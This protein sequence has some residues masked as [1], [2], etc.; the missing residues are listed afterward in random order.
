MFQPIRR[1]KKCRDFELGIAHARISKVFEL[2]KGRS[3][4]GFKSRV[5]AAFGGLD[6]PERLVIL[7]RWGL[8]G[9]E[10][11]IVVGA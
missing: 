6:R 3:E 5:K 9:V 11:A 7:V 10:M 2:F 8:G 4:S 1:P